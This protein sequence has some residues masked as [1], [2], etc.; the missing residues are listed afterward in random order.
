MTDHT[1]PAYFVDG[2][3]RTRAEARKLAAM[4][5]AFAGPER[6]E[7]L[8]L[9]DAGGDHLM[10]R[11]SSHFHRNALVKTGDGTA[12]SLTPEQIDQLITWLQGHRED[13]P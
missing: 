5:L 1:A 11:A 10:V 8:H 2:G 7:R 3:H 13:N 4:L 6:G 12:V 9:Q